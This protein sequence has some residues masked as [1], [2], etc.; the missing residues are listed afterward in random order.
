MVRSIIIAAYLISASV[1]LFYLVLPSPSL[2][3]GIP[4]SLVSKETGDTSDPNIQAYF[5]NS[6]REEVISYYKSKYDTSLWLGIPLP[7]LRLKDYPPEE[8]KFRIQDQVRSSYLEE[9]VHPLRESIFINGFEPTDPKDSINIENQHF[10]NKI[11]V[12]NYPSNLLS[13]LF[14]GSLIL[15]VFAIPVFGARNLRALFQ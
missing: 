3:S 11:T 14:I 2:P 15:A 9:L 6:S 5:T 13:R 7:T 4:G 10:L 1:F 12:R 8:S